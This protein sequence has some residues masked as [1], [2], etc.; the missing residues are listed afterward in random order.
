[1]TTTV[2]R[3]VFWSTLTDEVADT[4]DYLT[5]MLGEQRLEEA[6]QIND[7]DLNELFEDLL[8]NLAGLEVLEL[9]SGSGYAPCMDSLFTRCT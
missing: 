8:P 1:M 3:D 2:S 5:I 7:S 4:G 9:A 6:A